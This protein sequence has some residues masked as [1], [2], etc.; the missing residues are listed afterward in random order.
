[1][2]SERVPFVT[3]LRGEKVEGDYLTLNLP[4][5]DVSIEYERNDYNDRPVLK[6]GVYGTETIGDVIEVLDGRGNTW[7]YVREGA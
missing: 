2:M 6:L 5:G 7:R 3:S 4:E 1:M